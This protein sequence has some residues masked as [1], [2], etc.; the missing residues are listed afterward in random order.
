[1]AV[2]DFKAYYLEYFQEGAG[3][4]DNDGDYHPNEGVW[5]SVG[6]CNAVPAGRHNIIN[7]PDGFK[8]TF[9]F[10]IGGLNP[11]G[12]EFQ[13]GERIRLTT[14][15][16]CEKIPLTVKGFARYQHQCKIWA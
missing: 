11:R 14:V 3:Y 5:V 1:M 7:L 9:S 8:D 15:F 16:G 12:R 10:T 6:K 4:Y 2:L 13:Y